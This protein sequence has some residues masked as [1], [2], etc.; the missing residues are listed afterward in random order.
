LID[1]GSRVRF[2]HPVLRSAVFRAAE[3]REL[4]DVH[5]A[6]AAAPYLDPDRRAWHHAQ[7]SPGPD[8]EIATELERSAD[9][10]RARGAV[11]RRQR[12]SSS[13]PPR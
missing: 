4:Q 6:L 3:V 12:R 10:A 8:E 9:R 1:I 13:G 11:W 5:A 2:R 7:A